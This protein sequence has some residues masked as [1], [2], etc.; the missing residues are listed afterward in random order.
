MPPAIAISPLAS[1]VS[2]AWRAVLWGRD[3]R[4]VADPK[5][6]DFVVAVGGIDDMRALDAGQHG[7]ALAS[8]RQA[9]IRSRA[10]ATLGALLRAEAVAAT[11]VPMSDECMTAS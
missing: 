5:I 8:P 9:P 6:A 2:S 10:S 1:T 3:D 7:E 4:I 11:R